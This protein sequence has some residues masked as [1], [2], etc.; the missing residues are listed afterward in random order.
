M[1]DQGISNQLSADDI[2]LLEL[3]HEDHKTKY[4]ETASVNIFRKKFDKLS[5]I[6]FCIS[7]VL[8][9]TI[10]VVFDIFNV[11]EP[12]HSVIFFMIYIVITTVNLLNAATTIP[13]IDNEI[14]LQTDQQSYIQGCISGIILLLVFLYNI[15]MEN[16]DMVKTYK[17]LIISVF[18]S[19]FGLILINR[20]N[21]AD[22]IR[23][24]RKIQQMFYN[25]G[26]ILFLLV[27]GMIYNFQ[28]KKIK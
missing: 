6:V 2:R 10:W 5:L 12:K 17:I 13:D 8:W 25:E 26:I 14:V 16:S 28:S 15:K 4:L 21:N 23:A 20:Q 19:S 3:E 11:F 18:V 24:I 22:N 9:T 1:S 27:L 7:I